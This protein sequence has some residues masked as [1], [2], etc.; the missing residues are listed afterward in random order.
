M[1]GKQKEGVKLEKEEIQKETLNFEQRDGGKNKRWQKKQGGD[2]LVHSLGSPK[3]RS[4]FSQGEKQ[5][6]S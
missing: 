5:G 2:T 6:H 4:S 1:E 3:P